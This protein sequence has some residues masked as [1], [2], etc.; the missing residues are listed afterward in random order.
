MD[1]SSSSSSRSS[2]DDDSSSSSSDSYSIPDL[3]SSSESSSSGDENESDSS[4]ESEDERA[5]YEALAGVSGPSIDAVLVVLDATNL[6]RNLYLLHQI[7]ELGHRCVVV[8]E[9]A[10]RHRQAAASDTLTHL[11]L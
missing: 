7:A 4:S 11:V 6:T 10:V 2:S 5:A 8:A 1:C 9:C 3:V